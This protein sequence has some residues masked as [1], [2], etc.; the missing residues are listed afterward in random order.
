ML[1]DLNTHTKLTSALII[2]QSNI[3][4]QESEL[5]KGPDFV[6]A[7]PGRLIDHLMNTQGFNL[8]DLEV[9][10]L[11][12]ADRLLEL[13]FKHEISEIVQNSNPDRQTLLFSATLS[14]KLDFIIKMA[15]HKPIRLKANPDNKMVGQLR[16]MYVKLKNPD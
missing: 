7:T 14:A 13:G 8:E 3:K 2:G 1:N 16:Q 11:D 6:I 5:R 9:L 10:V 12:E 15:L 4:K